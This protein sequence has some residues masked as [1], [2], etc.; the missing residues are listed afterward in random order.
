[1]ASSLKPCRTGRAK[2]FS[3]IVQP[4]IHPEWTGRS[5]KGAKDRRRARKRN[6]NHTSTNRIS[7][8]SP[9]RTIEY[10]STE[11]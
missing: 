11:L 4:S 7:A 2:L 1:M 3:G 6:R 10:R 9:V 5:D 8:E